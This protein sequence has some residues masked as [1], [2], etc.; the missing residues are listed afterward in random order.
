MGKYVLKRI[1]YMLVVLVVLSFLLFLIY[2]LVPNNRAY[3]DA[4]ADMAAQKTR[5]RNASD[6]EKDKMFDEMYLEYQRQYGTDT[7]NMAVRYLRWVGLMPNYYGKYSGLLQGDFGYSYELKDDVVNVVK[8]PM[9]NTIFINIF[10]TI[11]A[12]GITIPLGIV[13]AV[14]KGSKGDQAMQ[15]ITIIGYSLPT[16]VTAILFVWIFCSLL[17]IFPPSGMKTPGSN[18]TGWKWFVDRMYYMALPLITMTFCSLGSMTRYVRAS[19]IDALSLDC[20]RTARAKGVTEKAVIYSHAWRNAL[21]PIV[22]LVVGWFLGIFGGSLIFETTFGINGMGKLMISSL[23]TQDFDV[24]ILMQLFYVA[25]SLI[26]NLIIDIVYGL[27][28]PR[29]RVSA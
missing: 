18:Y 20:I 15:V 10:A 1:G 8:E 12:L 7:N 6:E 4:K 17:G 2:N 21:I 22:T 24:V 19:M 27:V 3:T 13:C 11:L 28:D 9:K 25:I 16:F 26:G 29:V 14:H 23:R 5:L